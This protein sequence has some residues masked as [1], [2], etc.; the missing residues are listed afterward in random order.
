MGAFEYGDTYKASPRVIPQRWPEGV[1]IIF[2]TG[3][4]LSSTQITLC[5]RVSRIH[6][7]PLFGVNNTYQK[8]QLDVHF[9]NNWQWWDTYWNHEAYPLHDHRAEKWTWNDATAAKY[10]INFIPAKWA[11]SLSTD[12]SYIHWAHGS[13]TEILG[14]AYHYGIRHMILVGYDLRYSAGYRR[15]SRKTGGLR[16][17]FGEYPAHLQHWPKVGPNGEMRG[18]LDKVYAKINCEALGLRI[19]NCTPDSALTMFENASLAE[20]LAEVTH[21]SDDNSIH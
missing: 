13:G 10:G 15:E 5:E 11:E 21:V 7:I 6:G 3:P 4:S 17:Y 2:G 19:T 14:I 16:H 20:T 12:P 9:A 18:L 1:G 8:I